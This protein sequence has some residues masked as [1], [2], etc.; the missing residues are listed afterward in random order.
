[1]K[2]PAC[3]LAALMIVFA[4]CIEKAHAQPFT[5]T[6][7]A[8]RETFMPDAPAGT[9]FA[10]LG[11]PSVSGGRVAFYGEGLDPKGVY[12]WNNGAIV[13]I[14][15]TTTSV[16]G[17]SGAFISLSNR[18]NSSD[19]AV[20]GGSNGSV[21]GLYHR[22]NNQLSRVVDTTVNAPNGGKFLGVFST[23]VEQG[24]VAFYAG[25]STASGAQPAVYRWD[26]GTVTTVADLSTPVPGGEG[27]F[28]AIE[29]GSVRLNQG[30]AYFVGVD[31]VSKPGVYKQSG[32]VLG[33]VVD[34]GTDGPAGMGK[35]T[36][37]ID[38]D[39][40]GEHSALRGATQAGG[41]G[42]YAAAGGQWTRVAANG[43]AAPGGG[44]FADFTLPLVSTN[45][46]VV[47]GDNRLGALYTNAGGTPRRIIGA[48]DILDGKKVMGAG[49]NLAGALDGNT[50]AI[51]VTFTDHAPPVSYDQAIYTVTLPVPP[52][53]LVPLTGAALWAARRS[54]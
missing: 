52:T 54:R 29:I 24:S 21:S 36:T 10:I 12:E 4:A 35:F 31:G 26:S 41:Y 17:A 34:T 23:G 50:L 22:Y 44:T 3:R 11:S 9:R 5:F 51:A 42:V 19:H 27:N 20:F 18:A 38:F 28:S 40:A 8:G 13:R 46:F 48:G 43:D 32:G 33:A 1:M 6:R 15:D 37:I 7:I 39:A 30:A 49:Y 53:A 16:P 25:H 2:S 47:F 45:G 14:A